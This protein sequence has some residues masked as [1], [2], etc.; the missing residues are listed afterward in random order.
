MFKLRFSSL[1]FDES[2]LDKFFLIAF[3]S[4]IEVDEVDVK[5]RIV[6]IVINSLL[7]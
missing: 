7:S 4:L 6:F 1:Q 2:I 5:N 3:F